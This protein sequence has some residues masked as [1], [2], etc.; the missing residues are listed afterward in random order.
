MML[1]REKSGS[2]GTLLLKVRTPRFLDD[3]YNVH[4]L[5]NADEPGQTPSFVATVAENFEIYWTDITASPEIS[6]VSN[7]AQE[8]SSLV[9]SIQDFVSG[10]FT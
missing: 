9:K 4:F 6:M 5:L 7:S 3:V 10:L 2:F 1:K 8:S